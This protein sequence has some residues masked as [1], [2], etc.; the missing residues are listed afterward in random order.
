MTE[1]IGGLESAAEPEE[2]ARRFAH[3][4][5]FDGYRAIAVTGVVLLHVAFASG[6]MYRHPSLGGYLFN[7]DFGVS[8]FFMIS[9]FLLYR[10][11]ASSHMAGRPGPAVRPYFRRRAL[12]ILPAYWVALTVVVYV[13]H[14]Q[15]I[16][17]LKEFLLLYGLLQIY[18]EPYHFHGIQQAWSLGTEVSFYVFL[19][20]YAASVRRLSVGVRARHRLALE[21]GLVALLCAIGLASRFVLMTARGEDTYSLTTLPVYLDLFALGMGLAVL[22]A[23]DASRSTP[24]PRLAAMGRRPWLWC[25]VAVA[26][27][28]TVVNRLD[29][30]IN[31]KTPL[32][33]GQWV[34]RDGLFGVAAF[35]LLVP[36]VF[37]PQSRGGVRR[38]LRLRPVQWLGMVSY[39]VYLWHEAAIDLYQHWTHTRFFTGAFPLMLTGT[40]AITL[41]IAVASYF[42]VERPALRLKGPRA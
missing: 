33:P 8:L 3:F 38:F 12:R 11:F 37:G 35:C 36:G 40:A 26:A 31:Y 1:T 2:D 39:G 5:C 16:H 29:I 41:A 20:L 13:L 28:W 10:P 19:P 6:F 14:Q 25:L 7:A 9:G 27:Y 24:A 15:H 30:P 34:A 42:V 18:S 32:T 17:S 21:L 22:S 4:P 23:W